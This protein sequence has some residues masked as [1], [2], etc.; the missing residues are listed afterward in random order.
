M[1]EVQNKNQTNLFKELG[2]TNLSDSKKK[3]LLGK[4]FQA[5]HLKVAERV[6]DFLTAKEQKQLENL[7]RSKAGEVEVKNF[8]KAKV[9]NLELIT[10]A[11]THALVA[12]LKR[13]VTRF[14]LN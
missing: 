6:L 4:F 5:V 11:E 8:L 3:L 2:L 12:A 10:K 1:L 14:Y 13:Q 7:Y 9:P